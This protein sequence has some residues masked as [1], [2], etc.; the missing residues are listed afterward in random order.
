LTSSPSQTVEPI[1]S[2]MPKTSA[3]RGDTMP[4]TIGRRSVRDI[5]ASMSRSMYM[6]SALAPPADR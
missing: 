2:A 3:S 6:L 4:V 1:A 5:T